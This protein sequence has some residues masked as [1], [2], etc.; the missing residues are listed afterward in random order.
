MACVQLHNKPFTA[1]YW[2]ANCCGNSGGSRVNCSD[3]SEESGKTR[4]T[5]LSGMSSWTWPR[6]T[7]RIMK[8]R[9]TDLGFV[10]LRLANRIQPERHQ[11]YYI[12]INANDLTMFAVDPFT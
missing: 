10:E 11:V 3:S 8:D 2:S 6:A 7:V 4:Q 12:G 1:L 9:P 5:R